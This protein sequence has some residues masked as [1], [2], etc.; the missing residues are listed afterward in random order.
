MLVYRSA[1]L[2]RY[3]PAPFYAA[4]L[5]NQPMGFWSPAVLVSD[6]RRHGI[7]VRRVDIQRSQARCDVEDD[8]LRLGFNTVHGVSEALGEHIVAARADRPFADLR[9]LRRRTG[10]ARRLIENLIAA[11]ALDGWNQPRRELVWALGTTDAEA[12]TLELAFAAQPVSL[13]PLSAVEALGLELAATGVTTGDHPLA[14]QRGHLRRQ[15]ILD[16]DEVRRC[17][18]GQSVRVAGWVVVHQA[19]PTAKGF[20]FV[21]LEDECGFINVIVRPAVYARFRRVLRAQ[22]VLIV[23]GTVEREGAVTNVVAGWVGAVER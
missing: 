17:P 20:H 18:A 9:D 15:G 16:S 14:S 13:P 11:G 6:A 3:H 21:T 5:N 1:W 7:E 22:P 12:G 2:K 19:P 4:L 10:L 8:G 23:A